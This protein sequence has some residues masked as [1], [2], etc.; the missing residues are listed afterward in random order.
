MAHVDT[1]RHTPSMWLACCILEG[2]ICVFFWRDASS[3][4]RSC[5]TVLEKL[6]LA[7]TKKG[8]EF[9]FL[10]S[11]SYIMFLVSA[12]LGLYCNMSHLIDATANVH[13][14]VANI[15]AQPCDFIALRMV[16]SRIICA[17]AADLQGP[18][19][20]RDVHFILHAWEWQKSAVGCHW[21]SRSDCSTIIAGEPLQPRHA[22]YRQ[23]FE[24]QNISAH[25]CWS[26]QAQGS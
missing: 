25:R 18:S 23:Q 2:S 3:E 5:L 14:L 1:A 16:L 12:F 4:V 6:C 19:W 20:T 13:K 11:L 7:P 9:C 26:P 21:V 10:W 24:S 22:L 15:I 17:F 8:M